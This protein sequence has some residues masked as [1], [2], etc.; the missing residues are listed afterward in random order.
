MLDAAKAFAPGSPAGGAS[1]AKLPGLPPLNQASA[2]T[3]GAQG[4]LNS[5]GMVV[6]FGGGSTV[7]GGVPW[8]VWAGAAVAAVIWAWKR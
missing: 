3:S 8:F 2:A 6:N 5:S 7:G 4:A 1:I